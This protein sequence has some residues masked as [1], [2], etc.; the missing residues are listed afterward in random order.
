MTE[1]LNV[2]IIED[3]PADADLIRDAL[4]EMGHIRFHSESVPRLSD[5]IARL[6][7]GGIDIVLTDLGLPDSQG[8]ATF[9]KLRQLAPD[10]AIIVLTCDNDQ[11]TAVAA[12]REGAQDFLV[13]DQVSGNLLLRAVRY[14]IERKQAEDEIKTL[15]AE[16]E[17]LLREVHHRVKNNMDVVMSLLSLQSDTLKD[18]AVICAL[19]D[20][21]NRVK[22]MMVLYDKLYRSKDFGAISAKEYITSLVDEIVDNFPKRGQVVIETRI[23]EVVLD[24]KILSCLGMILNELL[25]NTMKYAFIGRDNGLINV[26]F[27]IKDSRASLIVQDNGTGIPESVEPCYSRRSTDVPISTGF[28]MQ[29][30]GLLT[31][32]LGGTMTIDR[33][34]E[35]R[36][37]LEFEV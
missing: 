1:R 6:A 30:V 34:N 21:R 9:R 18:P 25:T 8:L 4:P 15:L 36:F 13:K 23:D 32:Q 37:I 19:Q 33:D 20:A 29:L 11:E 14:A 16:K 5:A 7:T 12:V 27:S 2:L 22:S 17:L 35:P 3:N 28:G 24:A 10:L 31:E 26:S